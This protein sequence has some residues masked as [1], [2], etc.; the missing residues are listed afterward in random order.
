MAIGAS[1]LG[2][3]TRVRD[4]SRVTRYYGRAR[5]SIAAGCAGLLAVAPLSGQAAADAASADDA[6]AAGEILVVGETMDFGV[7]FG[8]IQ[9]GSN[10]LTVAA[11][12]TIDGED[13][14]RL[15]E[16]FQAPIP[17]FR[18]HDRQTSWVMLAPFRSLRF[19]RFIHEGRKRTSWRVHLDGPDRRLRSEHLGGQVADPAVP[20]DSDPPPEVMLPEAPLDDLAVLYEM[21]RR[22]SEGETSFT[23]DR[24]YLAERSPAVFE[25]ERR[26]RTRVPAGR[27]DVYILKSVVPGMSMFGPESD[28]RIHVGVEPP[29]PIVMVTTQTKHGR[30]TMYLRDFTPGVARAANP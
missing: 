11:R 21:R 29:H 30:L 28:A 6:A 25:L 26:D 12:E 14:Y 18:I 23:I 2:R 17:F 4:A 20:D 9:L 15:E 1:P 10:Q 3:R 8:P 19:D 16:D 7:Q 22:I 27:F 13:V 24:Y 5:P